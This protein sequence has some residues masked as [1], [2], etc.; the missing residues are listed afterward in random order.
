MFSR[1]AIVNRGEAAMRL[2]HAVRDLNAQAGPGGHRI[3]T[4]ALHTE[5][6]RR[7]MFVREADHA[8][9][10]G[11]AVNRP[12][13][14]YAVLEKA[15]LET[16]ADA[17]WVGWGFVAEDPNFAE[18]CARI[19]V[20]FIG[21]SPEAMRKLGDKIGSKLI[22]EEVG[23]P[24]AP[25]S[26]GGVDTL[27]DAKAAAARIGYP[28]MLK[29]TAGGGGRGIRMVASDADL[30]DAY[31][32]TRAEAERAF[33]SGIVFLERLVTGARHVEVQVI[34]DGQGTAWAIGVR[35]CSIQRRNQK[36]IEESASP[37]LDH[38][39]TEEVK[40]SAERLAIAVGYAGAG[41]VEFLYHPAERLFAFLEVNTRLQ[42]EHPITEATTGTDLVKLQIHVASGGRLE[43]E[44]P[45]EIGH[46]VE[47]RLNAEDPDRDFAPSAGRIALL[48]LPS[49]P[50]IR[51]DT[52]VGEGDSIPAD[53]DSM[54]AKI[55]AFGR[56]RDEALARLRRAMTETTVVIEGGSTNKSFVLDLLDSPEVIDGSADTGWI[57][58]VRTQG[59]LVAHRHS[60]VALVAAGIEEYETEEAV[61]RTRLI[62]TAR[63]GRPQVQHRT[64]R[65]VDLK[66]RGTAYKLTVSRIGSH[67]FRVVI[68]AGTTEQ[69]VDA[70][71]DRI[72][73]Y[74]SRIT[75]GGRTLRLVTATHGSIQLVEVDGVTHRVSL[76]EGG[77]LRSPSPALVVATPAA[78]GDEVAAGS[79]VLVLES[80]KMET[81]LSAPFAA[82]VKELLVS[83]G[84]QVET[85]APLVRL[86][87]VGDG[88]QL[89]AVVEEEPV[90]LDLPNGS[91]LPRDLAGRAARNRGDLTAM[92]L[93]YDVDPRDEGR[94]LRTYLEERDSLVTEGVSPLQAELA[95]VEAFADFAELSRNRPADEDL[96]LE[97]RVHSPREH[98]H[99]YLQSFDPERG[100]L[101]EDFRAKLGRVLRHYGVTDLDR[102]PELEQA[103][104]RVFLAQQR[105]APEVQ[106]V[107]AL[108]QRWISEPAPLE[109]I[110]HDVLDRLVT[111]TQLRFPVVGDL[112]RSVRFRWFDQPLVD[113]ERESVLGGVRDQLVAIAGMPAGPDRDTH[114]DALAAIPEQIV[115][116]LAERIE[117]GVLPAWEPMLAVLIKR[118]YREHSLR[119]LREVGVD[120]RPFAVAAYTLDDRPRHLV[121]TIGRVDELTPGSELVEAVE[122]QLAT[123]PEGHQGV[124]DLYLAWSDAPESPEEASAALADRIAQIGF[125]HD[126]RRVAVAVCPGGDRPVGYFTFRPQ[127][128]KT[129]AE[130][131]L[132]RGVHPMVGR[133]LNLWRLREFDVTR[134]EAPEDVLLYRCVAPGNE[135][136]Q[137]LVAL[138]Q[139]R[140]LAVVRDE[141]GR[142]AGLPHAERA[143]ANCLEAI[144]RARSASGAAG[145]RLDM[146]YV[147]VHI[148]PAIDADVQQLTSLKDKIAPVTAG[149]GIEEVLVAGTI[150]FPDGAEVPMAARFHY[151]PGSGVVTSIEG[152]PT[153]H[154]KPLDDYRQK[155]VLARRRGVVY[156]YELQAMIAG[157]GGT[158]TEYDLDDTGKLAPVDRPYGHNKAGIIAGVISTPTERYPE[159]VKRVLLCGDP[160]RA[161]GAVSEAECAR[162]IA[163][164]DLAESMDVPV[165]WFA[166]S[167]GARI[168]MDSGTENMDWV[169]K[170]LKRIVE[171][172]QA[173]GEINIVVAGINVGAQP[174][175]NA[176]ATML[177][178]TKG[179][180]VMTPDSAMVLTGKQSLDF[181]GGVS[182]E[183]NF[184]IGGYDRVMGPNGQAQYWAPDLARAIGILMT[185]YDHTYVAPGDTGPRRAVTSD[186][187]D[188]DVTVYPHNPADSG[189]TT[190]G[191]IFSAETNPDRKKAFDIRTVMAA[192]ADQDH[193]TL[194]RWS[195]MAD[196]ETSVVYDAHVGGIPVALIGIESKSVA[197]R[198]FP[199][200]DGPDLYTAGTLFPKSSK[201][202]A[203]AIN[204]ASGNRPVVV[205]ANLSGFD[206]SPESMRNLQL[207]YGA[208]IG[209]AIVN[210][211]GPIVFCVVSRYHGGAFVV[212][213][214]ALNPRMTVLAVEGS[215]ASVIG[216]APAAA[217]VFTRDVDGRTAKDP[218]VSSI[219]HQ[220]AEASGAERASLATQLAD[221]RRDV[222]SEKLGE[223]ATEFDRV[224]NIHRAVAVGSVDEVIAGSD[225][226]P[227]I[228]A[229]L[230][231]GLA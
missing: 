218:R 144:R 38:A 153:E 180:L 97:N 181:S 120:G 143:I 227:K 94:T 91:S 81:A 137:R 46:A 14:D 72:D 34:A 99:T 79:P 124:V 85:G 59:R 95:I 140:Q 142:V 12:Y 182:A 51:V 126:V 230:E 221:T 178:H 25:W 176:E 92:L 93:G 89:A 39:Q 223:V 155:V 113:A 78:V 11:P 150:A 98:F 3:E 165:E 173:G 130:D 198:G 68:A 13:L 131:A 17:A 19:G 117:G 58:R 175:W 7:A 84:S 48:D 6:E 26:R 139:I 23:V 20:T 211:D 147:W 15:L 74:K 102:T 33:G 149:A 110:A 209:R 208:E 186:P 109:G 210:F 49:G 114:I 200:T 225:L 226:R 31:E 24:V 194:E 196:A 172:T 47:A 224:H 228:I 188:R 215:Y 41:T 108:L 219:E 61:E 88:T 160:L 30:T 77:V 22:A 83:I 167:A 10:L 101:P 53:F 145:A 64:G 190:I 69:T 29:A 146:N 214:K 65:A 129:M 76:D 170:A 80:M 18:L 199:P 179:I 231:S 154:L 90:D 111:A 174:Y 28:L 37:V 184:G 151:Q 67:R 56:D 52:G 162:I 201:K 183:D 127:P 185:H 50:G 193:A 82:R 220:L 115:R 2:I 73:Q 63:G 163:A 213:S 87:P 104:F 202:T 141:E 62:E 55:I 161:L 177:M 135:S 9:D 159:G 8:Y 60:G 136:D 66:L 27:E 32:R 217:V 71:I 86:E 121:T 191:D 207:E 106:L 122:A 169:A 222:R 57:D 133:R 132:V 35:D 189:F 16:K 45:V 187:F 197:R 125:A 166:V 192:V 36:V 105:S 96:H 54:I 42:V 1:I 43:G 171:F 75:I 195:G 157:P 168:S 116:F 4:I 205:I 119:D 103:V 164:L 123:A 21:P 204:A 212:F 134:L 229:A 107:T 206:G 112:A 158:A 203:R 100:A 118:H 152:P 148:W 5:G 40:A 138:A 128:D 44:K 216:G 70:E 156:P